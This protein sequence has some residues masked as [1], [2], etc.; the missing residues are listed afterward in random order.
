MSSNTNEE[1]ERSVTVGC[2]ESDHVR[3]RVL[4]R[5]RPDDHDYW[6]GNWLRSVVEVRAGS[7]RGTFSATLRTDEFDG[8]LK[9]I[10]VMHNHVTGEARFVSTENW[11]SIL[12][13]CDRTGK[14]SLSCEARD[15]AAEAVL[16]FSGALDQTY[17]QGIITELRELLRQYSVLG[18]NS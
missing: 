4:A 14:V 8:F 1:M 12:L 7:F 5:E 15:T 10:E 17:L 13:K 3:I 6:D 2:I 18:K 11:L 16:A 9:Q